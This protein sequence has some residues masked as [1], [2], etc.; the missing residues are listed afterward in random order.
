[1]L[2]MRL[3]NLSAD[4]IFSVRGQYLYIYIFIFFV[5]GGGGGG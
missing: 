4:V 3:K 1:M 2:G 5:G